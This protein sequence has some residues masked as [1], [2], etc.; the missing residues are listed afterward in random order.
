MSSCKSPIDLSVITAT[1]VRPQLLGL[2]LYQFAEQSIGDLR[3]EQ[4]VVSDG[5]DDRARRIAQQHRARYVERAATGGLWGRFAKDDGIASAEGE[6]VCF[7][8]DDN[9]YLPHALATL[10]AAA[11]GVDLGVVQVVHDDFN[12]P[13]PIP[14]P[15]TGTFEFG[16]ID[17]MCVCVRRELARSVPWA[18]P[19]E[20]ERGEDHR[21]I[22][23]LQKAGATVRFIPI[24]IG[25][26]ISA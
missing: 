9:R 11:Y 18:M 4:I 26:H 5:P 1:W 2:C 22:L 23:R 24:V 25:E 3:C 8:D 16:N 19:D 13:H 6:Y 12:C 14:D 20:P 10:Y 21:W 15:W 7:W 17:T